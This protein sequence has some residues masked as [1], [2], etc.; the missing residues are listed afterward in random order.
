MKCGRISESVYSGHFSTLGYIWNIMIS[1]IESR[2]LV[3]TRT[4]FSARGPGKG[5]WLETIFFAGN[6]VRN[7]ISP[8]GRDIGKCCQHFTK[9]HVQGK[10]SK[11]WTGIY[12]SKPD[13]GKSPCAQPHRVWGNG[14]RELNDQLFVIAPKTPH[15]KGWNRKIDNNQICEEVGGI[16]FTTFCKEITG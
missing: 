4:F 12:L 6:G 2:I 1:L 7:K 14:G 13:S 16:G 15:Q 3:N 11:N 9:I 10:I 5:R 8:R